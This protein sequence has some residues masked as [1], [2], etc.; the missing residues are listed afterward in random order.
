MAKLQ[1]IFSRIKD[2]KKEQKEIK[3]VYRDALSVSKQYQDVVEEIK[4]LREKKKKIEADIKSQFT[5]EFDKLDSISLD[6]KTD[7]ELLS[8]AA[9]NQLM[10]GETV[11]ITDEYDNEYE[12][13]FSVKFRKV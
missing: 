10:K 9:L 13:L 5:S 6:I 1:D 2:L 4:G 11:Q 8:D 12:P 7:N 3:T